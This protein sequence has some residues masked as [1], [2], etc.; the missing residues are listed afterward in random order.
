MS[1]IYFIQHKESGKYYIG[2]TVKSAEERILD[3]FRTAKTVDTYL[4]RAIRKY[5]KDAFTYGIIESCLTEELN[6]KETYWIE[7]LGSLAPHGYNMTRGGEGGDTSLSPK[8]KEWVKYSIANGVQAGANNSMYGKTS[9]MKDKK[10]TNETKKKQSQARQDYWDNVPPENRDK[11]AKHGNKN[12][13]F[14]KT[15][16]NAVTIE[17]NGIVYPSIS[18]AAKQLK[19]SEQYVRHHGKRSGG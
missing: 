5:G 9:A 11:H 13:M 15:P 4:Y 2:Q 16:T 8:Y 19:V 10:H 6:D 12:P 7:R 1:I 18:G 17:L 3:H 14:G